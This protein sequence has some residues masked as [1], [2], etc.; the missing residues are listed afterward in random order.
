M[1]LQEL[2]LLPD[3]ELGDEVERRHQRV[4][5]AQAEY[6]EGLLVVDNRPSMVPGARPGTTAR[7]FA[8][9]RLRSSRATKDVRA[10]HALADAL[11]MLAKALAAGEVTREHVDGAIAVLGKIPRH[12]LDD[13]ATLAKVDTWL[14][15]TARTLAPIQTEHVAAHLL[16][17][18]DPDGGRTYDPAS[19]ERRELVVAVD[20]TG[21][22]ERS[23]TEAADDQD[24]W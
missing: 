16:A 2:E 18:L 8:R 11:P 12:F 6:L 15:N 5:Q 10:A 20:S 7:T 9:H 23:S 24:Y 3:G 14:T 13:P 19:V 17:H 4:Q 1:S 21:M 22:L